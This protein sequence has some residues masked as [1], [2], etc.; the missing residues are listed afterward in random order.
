MDNTYLDDDENV[1]M[2]RETAKAIGLTALLLDLRR[3]AAALAH[4]PGDAMDLQRARLTHALTLLGV[5]DP[6]RTQ[7]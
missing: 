4:A 3:D 2:M 5:S 7:S 1:R 6:G